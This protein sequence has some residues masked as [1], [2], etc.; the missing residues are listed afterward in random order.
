MRRFCLA[1]AVAAVAWSLVVVSTGGFAV[2]LAGIRISSR[3]VLNPLLL[4]LI[5]AVAAWVLSPP[6]QRGRTL[7]L[8]LARFAT[9]LR[10]W[11]RQVW[12]ASLLAALI[13]AGIVIVGLTEGAL[14]AGGS[15]SYGYVSQAEAWASGRFRFDEP[16]IRQFAG[17][18]SREALVPL[19][20]LP[21]GNGGA[22]V[23]MYPPGLPMLMGV[24]QA[25]GGREAV[26]Y[27]VPLLGGLAVWATYLMGMRLA[28]TAVGLLSAV[29]L[30]TSPVFLFQLTAAPM[31]DV[32]V[33]AWW[34]FALALVLFDTHGAAFAAGLAVSAAVLTRPNLVPLA[35]IP[36]ALLAWNAVRE[37]PVSRRAIQRV[38]LFAAGVIPGCVTVGVLNLAWYGSPLMSG[39]G[40]PDALYHWRNFWPNLARYPRW[41]L[42]S[43]TPLVLA[44]FTAPW[45]VRR[46]APKGAR[47]DARLVSLAWLG[48]VAAVLAS[49]VFYEPFNAWWF[50]RFLLPAFPPLL[51]LTSVALI[52]MAARLP[53]V[54]RGLVLIALAAIVAWHGF[55]YARDNDAFQAQRERKY[56]VAGDYVSRRLPP[57]A[58][59][60]SMLHSGS[61]RYYSGRATVRFDVIPESRLDSTIAELRRSGYHPYLLLEPSEIAVFQQRYAG[62]SALARLDWPPIAVMRASN[63]RIYDPAD[64]SASLAGRP[65][66]TEIV[67]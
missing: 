13:S 44:A 63:I 29:L 57:R 22:I 10:G 43:Q 67:P 47:H 12:F 6:T 8:D 56:A 11:T 27:V 4:A 50:L 41:L 34:A 2:R 26:F 23:P 48:F 65:P 40:S 54:S 64:R 17:R 61:I 3:S 28:G 32:A 33:T 36:G 51:V 9:T 58:A 59:L 19:A 14:V 5:A 62:H 20:Y 16:L 7:V 15:D 66:F 55:S 21:I 38:M 30:A 24:F 31:S 53:S 37:R 1:I 52:A 49:Y 46:L 35:L 42:E 45:L 39:Y 18:V 25:V 60:L